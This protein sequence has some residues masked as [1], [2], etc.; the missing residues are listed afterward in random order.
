MKTL[1]AIALAGWFLGDQVTPMVHLVTHEMQSLSTLIGQLPMN[2]LLP[3][4]E[5]KIDHVLRVAQPYI[6]QIP[7]QEALPIAE[8]RMDRAIQA[9]GRVLPQ[10]GHVAAN[11][12]FPPGIETAIRHE[13]NPGGP[14]SNDV[15]NTAN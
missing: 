14:S 3:Q 7:V 13:L 4:A 15:L 1:I 6:E 12:P 5:D 11:H 2:E 8:E 10:G 9:A